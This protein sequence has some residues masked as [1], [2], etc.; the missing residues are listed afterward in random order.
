MDPWGSRLRTLGSG[1]LTR[2][3]QIKVGHRTPALKAHLEPQ[4]V[5][6][7]GT[8]GS[9]DLIVSHSRETQDLRGPCRTHHIFLMGGGNPWLLA[10]RF[11]KVIGREW[12]TRT[13]A[14][15][16]GLFGCFPTKQ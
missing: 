11:H 3:C 4:A 1:A 14:A 6:Q 7:W 8:P 9:L 15:N 12:Q 10:E 5:E 2:R 13:L 16:F